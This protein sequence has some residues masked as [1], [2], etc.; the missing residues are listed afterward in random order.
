MDARKLAQF[1]SAGILTFVTVPEKEMESIIKSET[2]SAS[3]WTKHHKC[4]LDRKVDELAIGPRAM[5]LIKCLSFF[6]SF[7]A[8][9]TL[10]F[11]LNPSIFAELKLL[12]SR[13]ADLD[14]TQ[15]D[16]TQHLAFQL[17]T[18]LWCEFLRSIHKDP[19]AL[20][21]GAYKTYTDHPLTINDLWKNFVHQMRGFIVH[22]PG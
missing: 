21:T 9:Q 22:S 18:K 2:K 11:I 7:P 14:Q 17:R 13:P 3:H 15:S 4:W 5:Y 16:Q 20:E 19:P 10:A 12:K 8:I 6:L 1:L